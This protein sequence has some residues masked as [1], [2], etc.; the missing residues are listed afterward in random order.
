[1]SGNALQRSLTRL[2]LLSV[3]LEVK[4]ATAVSCRYISTTFDETH[5]PFLRTYSESSVTLNQ[6]VAPPERRLPRVYGT[7]LLGPAPSASWSVVNLFLKAWGEWFHS[8]SEGAKRPKTAVKRLTMSHGSIRADWCL[9]ALPLVL[10]SLIF[11]RAC[12]I[13]GAASRG[14]IRSARLA[15]KASPIRRSPVQAR[16]NVAALRDQQQCKANCCNQNGLG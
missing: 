13:P 8:A 11:S 2:K 16:A 9:A 4:V 14:S 15:A 10:G 7:S 6:Y 3:I 1:M 12:C 5:R